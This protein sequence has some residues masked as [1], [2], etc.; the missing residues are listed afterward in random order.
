MR[1]GCI[2]W[3]CWGVAHPLSNFLSLLL[4]WLKG[5]LLLWHVQYGYAAFKS[6]GVHS[7]GNGGGDVLMPVNA[8]CL[9]SQGRV[10]EFHLA[11]K[12]SGN[13]S[14]IEKSF[15]GNSKLKKKYQNSIHFKSI[16]FWEDKY[17]AK[18]LWNVDR[19]SGKTRK[20]SGK[21]QGILCQKFGRHHGIIDR[22]SNFCSNKVLFILS[23]HSMKW[24]K[25]QTNFFNWLPVPGPY[26]NTSRMKWIRVA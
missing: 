16:W 13:F 26:Q 23:A 8:G 3:W 11:F 5:R 21:S 12:K 6:Y 15:F 10:G 24:I 1:R 4:I 18:G 14:E 2:W 25:R 9:P 22:H 17:Q 7:T 20:K 19:E